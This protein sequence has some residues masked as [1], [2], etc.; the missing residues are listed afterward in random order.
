MGFGGM[1]L[2]M[3][4]VVVVVVVLLLRL[5]SIQHEIVSFDFGLYVSS[6]QCAYFIVDSLC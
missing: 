1:V 2:V 3:L 5:D 4:M 6:K